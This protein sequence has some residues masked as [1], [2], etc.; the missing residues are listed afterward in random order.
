LLIPSLPGL[1]EEGLGAL[2]L[3]CVDEDA[4]AGL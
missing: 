1:L 4:E 3:S 2:D